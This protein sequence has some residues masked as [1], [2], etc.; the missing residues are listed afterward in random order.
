M[1]RPTTT[2]K[3]RLRQPKPK[4][5]GQAQLAIR[6]VSAPE[7]VAR[8]DRLLEGRHYLGRTP[9]VGD[10]LRQVAEVAG[11]WVGLLAWGASA[12]RLKDRDEWIG[13]T[14][15]QR[16]CRRKLVVQN[17]RFLLPAGK[18]AHPNR[19]SQVLAAAA[20]A[21]PEQWETRFGYRPLL[22][23]TF[24]DPEQYAGTCYRA[25]GWLP[26]G[27]SQGYRRHRAD[28]YEARGRP[29][30]LWLRPLHAR[31]RDRLCA[32]ELEAEQR[33][34][35]TAAEQGA[36]PLKDAQMRSLL[37][38]LRK[39]PDPRAKNSR[40]KIGPVMAIVAMAL[41]CG[42][43]DVAQFHRL[44]WRLTQKQRAA[45]WLPLAKGRRRVREVP[46]YSVYYQVLARL[47]LEAFARILT[48][49]LGRQ[50]GQLPGALALDGKLVRETIGTLS[51]VDH[52]TGVPLAQAMIRQKEGDGEHGELKTAQRL[53]RSLARL[54]GQVVTADALHAQRK[55]ARAVVEQG[56][57]YLLQVKA[58][59]PGLLQTARAVLAKA[60]PFWPSTK[61]TTAAKSAGSSSSP[62]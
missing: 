26:V 43:R 10:F 38:V 41:L 59:Q 47:D 53:I 19:A 5:G 45:L 30:R 39:L 52:E 14:N 58:N 37:D 4:A 36:L 22:A 15:A 2:E 17:R 6:V 57:D 48:E 8:F 42:Q 20:R 7:E 12:Y 50:A 51:L 18:G 33:A 25:A 46:G 34:G 24:T 61:S 9:P 62:P 11:E 44:G 28:F 40:F 1:N 60:P 56:G 35:E 49:W 32:A 21:L 23:E 27:R 55:T 31:A 29:K 54:D 13:W 3:R 16:S